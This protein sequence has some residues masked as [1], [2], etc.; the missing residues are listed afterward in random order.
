M[1][2]IELNMPRTYEVYFFRRENKPP[3]PGF[4]QISIVAFSFNQA[5][6][7]LIELIPD[8]MHEFHFSHSVSLEVYEEF[9][10]E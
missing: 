3:I 6:T 8:Q 1:L 7:F 4:D 10:N 5:Q 9:L 2:H